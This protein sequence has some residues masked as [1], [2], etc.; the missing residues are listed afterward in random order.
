MFAITI[1]S[2]SFFSRLSSLN[3]CLVVKQPPSSS[4]LG[5]G[6]IYLFLLLYDLFAGNSQ[7]DKSYANVLPMDCS[8]PL[9][10]LLHR[11]ILHTRGSYRESRL[12]HGPR[13]EK[14]RGSRNFG[15]PVSRK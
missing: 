13:T 5:F 15:F 10:D 1:G 12:W 11:I 14:N 8:L 2:V 6:L 9:S 3:D 7:D 4:H